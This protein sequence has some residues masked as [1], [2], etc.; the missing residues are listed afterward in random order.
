MDLFL[1]QLLEGA[2][3]GFHTPLHVCFQD[4]VELLELSLADLTR[5]R[6]QGDPP[7]GHLLGQSG[8]AGFIGPVPNHGPGRLLV[9]INLKLV[10]GGGHLAEAKRFDGTGGTGLF[11]PLAGV[12]HH[13]SN[14]AEHRTCGQ[15]IASAEGAVLDQQGGYGA[16]GFIQV[17]LNHGAACQA[18]G[19][20]L[21]VFDIGDQQDHFQQFVDVLALDGAYR[22]HHGVATPILRH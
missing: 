16:L 3:N 6:G 14:L 5:H 21:Q 17:G 1:G 8:G 7:G 2:Q 19:I 15:N 20:G 9:E 11:D 12:I 4:Q 18:V 13:G 22:H 10:A